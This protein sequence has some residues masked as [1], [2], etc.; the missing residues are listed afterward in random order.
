MKQTLGQPRWGEGPVKGRVNLWLPRRTREDDKP[1][2]CPRGQLSTGA[3]VA[4]GRVRAEG[5]PDIQRGA[6]EDGS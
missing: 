1:S 5:V 3:Q 6:A 4:V 2:A